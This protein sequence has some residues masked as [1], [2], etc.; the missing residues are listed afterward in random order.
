MKKRLFMLV[1][2]A[3]VLPL[4]AYAQRPA[5]P[6]LIAVLAFGS[7]ETTGNYV[8]VLKQA[9]RE[10]GW[11]EGRNVVYEIRW[12]YGKTERLPDL[13]RELV[14]LAPDVIWTGFTPVAIAAR[15]AT[16]TIPIVGNSADAVGAGLAQ[17]LARPGGNFTGVSN[18]NVDIGP[19][20]L[21][22]LRAALPKIANVAVLWNPTN[23]ASALILNNLRVAAQSLKVN[24]LPIEARTPAEIE[25]AF[26]RMSREK[27]EA[28]VVTA[29]SVFLTQRRQIDELLARHRLPSA[30][31]GRDY[32]GTGGLMSYAQSSDD[33]MQRSASYVD[34]ILKGAKPGDLPI[35]QPTKLELVIDFRVAKTL[36]LTIPKE[37]LLRANEVIR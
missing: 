22:M 35:E 33:A 5:K 6:K 25:Q 31:P 32:L 12:A 37:L 24:L 29:D 9:L 23:T 20:L 26:A 21:E 30:L 27:L 15:Q 1:T 8:E 3:G 13:A 18:V 28:V 16:A 2:F 14:A 17:S 10:L 11:V 36:G 4:G 19:K 34:R 7:P